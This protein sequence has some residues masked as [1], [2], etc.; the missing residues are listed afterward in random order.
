MILGAKGFFV[1]PCD[2]LAVIALHHHRIP[3]FAAPGCFPGVARSMPTSSAVDRVA[4]VSLP[5]SPPLPA[6]ASPAPLQYLQTQPEFSGRQLPVY[7]TPTGWKFFGNLLDER[8]AFGG[9]G[10]KRRIALCG[11]ESFGATCNTC[12]LI[13]YPVRLSCRASCPSRNRRVPRARERRS[14]GRACLAADHRAHGPGAI[15]IPDSSYI[16]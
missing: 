9:G 15:L 10:M 14:V 13:W 11:E 16:S 8:E 1:C 3:L 12:A 2:S 4:Q 6:P 5:P 7:V